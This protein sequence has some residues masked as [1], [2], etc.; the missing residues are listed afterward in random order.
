MGLSAK[1]KVIDSILHVLYHHNL[2]YFGMPVSVNFCS[3]EVLSFAQFKF[4]NK[5]FMFCRLKKI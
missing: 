5:F 1:L 4:D 2:F 3:L